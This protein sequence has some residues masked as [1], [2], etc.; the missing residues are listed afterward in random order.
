MAI[1]AAELQPMRDFRSEADFAPHQREGNY[2][3]C[4][5]YLVFSLLNKSQF[6]LFIK[7]IH[8]RSPNQEKFCVWQL[9]RPL[10]LW[11]QKK[12]IPNSPISKSYEHTKM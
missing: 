6:F 11:Q 12:K 8:K 3:S 10:R 7:F 2:L 4:G 9:R 1:D 5:I